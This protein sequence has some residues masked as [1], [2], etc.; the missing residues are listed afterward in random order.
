ML[1]K[2]FLKVIKNKDSQVLSLKSGDA[3]AIGGVSPCCSREFKRVKKNIKVYNLP[4][5]NG[6]ELGFNFSN[7]PAGEVGFR[8]AMAHAIDREKICSVV[9]G[10]HAKPTYTT[11]FIAGCGP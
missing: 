8:K 9:F 11:F 7:Y 10:G 6:Y 4:S 3:D 2:W 1:M 5:T